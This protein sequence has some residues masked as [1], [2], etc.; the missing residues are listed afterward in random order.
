MSD[1]LRLPSCT[2]RPSA[3][4]AF[5]SMVGLNW[6]T[7]MKNGITKSRTIRTP[8][9]IRMLRTVWFMMT[10]ERQDR[11]MWTGGEAII[12]QRSWMERAWVGEER[13]TCEIAMRHAGIVY[14]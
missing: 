1:R 13:N 14:G 3:A 7:G 2:L 5:S 8:T 9:A 11:W 12:T 6:L 10:S 4:E